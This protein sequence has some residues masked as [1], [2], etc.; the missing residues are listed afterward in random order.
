MKKR[1]QQP[2]GY[3]YTIVLR[4]LALHSRFS[5]SLERA[6][7]VYHSMFAP[8]SL[9]RPSIIHTNAAIKV[10]AQVGDLDAMFGIAARLPKSGPRAA[11]RATFTTVF[12]ALNRVVFDDNDPVR[13]ESLLENID[14]RQ[15]AVLKGRRMWAD[16]IER[17]NEGDM[18]LDEAL[19]C[20]VGRLL[21]LADVPQ[22]LDDVFS[23][24]E[25][26]MGIPRQTPRRPR[27]IDGTQSL[28][29][30]DV[31][32][33]AQENKDL[34]QPIEP[35]RKP[36]ADVDDEFVPGSEF[37][38]LP[39][40]AP[41]AYAIPSRSTLSLVVDACTR[42][43]LF[44][45]AQDYW[46][47]L[48][49]SR[50]NIVPDTAN[51]HM[52]LRLLRAQ[53]ASR[54]CVEIVEDMRDGLGTGSYVPSSAW[55]SE[56]R[57]ASSGVTVSTFR[58][59]LSACRRDI[60][61]PNVMVHA[62]KLVRIM[63]DCLPEA[64]IGFLNTFIE[65]TREATGDDYRAL[66]AALRN[67]DLGVQQ[68]V[69]RIRFEFTEEE[70]QSE[71]YLAQCREV[72]TLLCNLIGAYQKLLDLHKPISRSMLASPQDII[73]ERIGAYKQLTIV[74]NWQTEVSKRLGVASVYN[75]AIKEE[76]VKEMEEQE[77]EE[78]AIA[79]SDWK[80]EAIIARQKA[81][82]YTRGGRN[83]RMAMAQYL[84]RLENE[85]M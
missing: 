12:N 56:N 39:S 10:C 57:S 49:G 38:P 76:Q 9:V 82:K 14:K 81:E 48:T 52:Y 25:Q 47:L 66:S 16:I 58:I 71:K 50:Y 45:A 3:T 6:L 43:K 17:W 80:R 28:S 40:V 74:S 11:D 85:S 65:I 68:I 79:D 8:D 75:P 22:D 30:K 53:R 77:A 69:G 24:L 23:L 36:F 4:G 2:D 55:K 32:S 54:Q 70:K 1:R 13:D 18:M 27:D 63:Y 46:T 78:V 44:S 34:V 7:T 33:P 73:K 83:K 41:T 19:I 60:K 64:D 26:T 51:Y 15:N 35:E 20:A 61:N 37:L 67:T 42:L 59:A 72:N 84:R 21:L 62:C 31:E 29:E 5:K